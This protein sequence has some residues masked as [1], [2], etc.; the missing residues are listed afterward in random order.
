MGKGK[1]GARSRQIQPR[2]PMA[3]A[4]RKLFARQLSRMK[5][6]EPG[7]RSGV[8]IESVHQ[9]RVAIRRMRSLFRLIGSS[10]RPKAVARHSRG[11]RRAARALGEIRDLDVLIE[12]LVEF[13]GSAGQP[14]SE[15]LDEII[16]RLDGRRQ[17]Y[18]ERL[19]ALFDSKSYARFLR[20]FQRMCRK[21]GRGAKPIPSPV[22][23]HQVRHVLPL[24]LHERLARVRAYDSALPAAKD[25]TLHA[26]RVECKQLRYALEFFLPL[27]G[28]SAQ[29][30]LA[31][32]R[33]LQDLLGRINDIA[34]FAES[35][36]QLQDLSPGQADAIAAYL[37]DRERELND[38]RAQFYDRWTRFN[39]R[40]RQ[41]QFSDALLVLR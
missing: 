30:F 14:F 15:P 35:L 12:D 41:R 38:L 23:P 37:A 25:E 29:A 6:H 36:N 28:K 1:D 13:Q 20:R 39:A 26:L 5:R 9:M 7:S 18:R 32:V 10:Y 16:A 8:D 33:A 31:E 24:L 4:G 40:A 34:V 19:N 27:L 3:E 21:P 22:A 2:D 17:K 11:L